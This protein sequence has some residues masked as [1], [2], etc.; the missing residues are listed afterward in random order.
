M[1]KKF[2]IKS[3]LALPSRQI[4]PDQVEAAI[5]QI[6]A[7]P[8]AQPQASPPAN[9][10]PAPAANELREAK[11][12]KP[13]PTTTRPARAYSVSKKEVNTV[14]EQQAKYAHPTFPAR[15]RRDADLPGEPERKVRLSVD[16]LPDIHKSLKIKAIQ[17]D[18]DIMH[19]VEMLIERDLRV[20]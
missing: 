5:R 1:K 17:N 11:M 10:E 16:V 9:P 7:K 12:P 2:D 20:R 14:A 15:R 3:T 19:Y 4:S 8:A 6:H 13:K 18:T